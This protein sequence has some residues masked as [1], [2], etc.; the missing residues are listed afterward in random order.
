MPAHLFHIRP[1]ATGRPQIGTERPDSWANR[2]GEYDHVAT[3][4]IGGRHMSTDEA[5]DAVYDQTQNAA[6]PWT[7]DPDVLW[8]SGPSQ[9]STSIGDVVVLESQKVGSD[10]QRNGPVR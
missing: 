5:L 6:H 7:G 2:K 8:T 1:D 3:L 9:R 10:N 4:N